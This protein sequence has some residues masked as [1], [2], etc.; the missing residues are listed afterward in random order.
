M[1][2][3][4]VKGGPEICEPFGFD[5]GLRKLETRVKIKYVTAV[6]RAGPTRPRMPPV[7]WHLG[8]ETC[9][10]FDSL[11]QLLFQVYGLISLLTK[12]G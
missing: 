8:R 3:T 5:L 11:S 4:L 10:P 7:S 6:M 2:V 9:H 12:S 1:A